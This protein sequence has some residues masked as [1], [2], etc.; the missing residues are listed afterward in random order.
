MLTAT[1][2]AN[3]Q[4]TQNAAMLDKCV[5]LSFV[6]GNTDQYGYEMPTYIEGPLTACGLSF[7]HREAEADYSQKPLADATLRLPYSTQIKTSD[8]VRVTH[9]F[10]IAEPNPY[11]YEIVGLPLFGPSGVFVRLR[12][13]TNE[14]ESV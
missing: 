13:I 10:G 9:R 1:D 6:E 7:A 12:R 4:E 14:A 5:I 3:M 2:L 11:T 8:R